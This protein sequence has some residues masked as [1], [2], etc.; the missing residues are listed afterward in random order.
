MRELFGDW[1]VSLADAARKPLMH[2]PSGP[3]VPLADT[4]D[5]CPPHWWLIQT[6]RWRCRKCGQTYRPA[7]ARRRR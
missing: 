3:S 1:T 7:E 4:V 2:P 5:S 6:G